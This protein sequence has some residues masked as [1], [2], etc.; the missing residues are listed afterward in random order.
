MQTSAPNRVFISYARRD[1]ADLAQ[2][3]QKDLAA[4]GIDVWLDKNRLLGGASWTNEIEKWR[5]SE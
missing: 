1:G 3:L 2:R 5:G 4:K